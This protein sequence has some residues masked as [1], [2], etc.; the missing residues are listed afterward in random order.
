MVSYKQFV[1]VE[2]QEVWDKY[3][4]VHGHDP[5]PSDLAHN[6][7]RRLKEQYSHE[8]VLE[9]I[10]P[11]SVLPPPPLPPSERNMVEIAL[12]NWRGD[13][14]NPP[15]W[16]FG[17]A[18]ASLNLFSLE[19][20]MD[21]EV[22]AGHTHLVVNG[23]QHNWGPSKGHP[24]WTHGGYNA[25]NDMPKFVNILKQIRQSGLQPV[26]GCVDQNWLYSKSFNTILSLIR[27]IVDATWEH[28]PLYILSWEWNEV[29]MA[30]PRNDYLRRIFN[31]VDF[32]GRDAG[33]H[34]APPSLNDPDMVHGGYDFYGSLPPHAVRLAQYPNE[35]TF[36]QLEERIRLGC[37]VN[38]RT[39]TKFCYFEARGR[40]R[41]DPQ[42]TH[43]AVRQAAYRA[44]VI[45]S[46]YMPV[47]RIGSLNG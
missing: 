30:D 12:G 14:L 7:W 26:V 37:E 39:N 2:A 38:A 34:Y 22:S 21:S 36:P 25:F 10:V 29:W 31:E 40:V 4:K 17:P 27:E 16:Y 24:E 9:R 43:D 8:R 47:S 41:R 32:H 15:D 6:S 5:A 20:Y 46:E 35:S 3:V 13:F 44:R 1:K 45:M 28:T 23:H 11:R 18:C 33:I 19:D 42:W